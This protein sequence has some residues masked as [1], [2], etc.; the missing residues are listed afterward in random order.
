MHDTHYNPNSGVLWRVKICRNEKN[1][2]AMAR[3]RDYAIGQYKSVAN[4]MKSLG[5]EKPIHIGE[6]GW[7]TVSNEMY[8]FRFKGD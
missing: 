7:A 3:A 5:V 2:A 4:Y 8:E 6:T 1:D